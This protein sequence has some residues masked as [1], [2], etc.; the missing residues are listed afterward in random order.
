V[1]GIAVTKAVGRDV[2]FSLQPAA[3]SC[4]ARCTPPRSS[5]LVA[6]AAAAPRRP[7]ARL[8]NSSP[9]QWVA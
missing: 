8:G 1:G 9:P 6:A 3:T 4:G 2:F 5:A 7:L